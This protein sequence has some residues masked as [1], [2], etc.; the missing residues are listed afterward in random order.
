MALA[1]KSQS[2]GFSISPTFLI[3]SLL[4]VS[5]T[6]D[7]CSHNANLRALIRFPA[8][9]TNAP[10]SAEVRKGFPIR[11]VSS[12]ILCGIL[13]PQFG[14]FILLSG[15][16]LLHRHCTLTSSTKGFVINDGGVI[17]YR[18]RKMLAVMKALAASRASCGS[19]L[20]QP[21]SSRFRCLSSAFVRSVGLSAHWYNRQAEESTRVCCF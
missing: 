20:L 5:Y 8:A 15:Q 3:S 4:F 12:D 18:C 11:G 2:R 7:I 16:T 1:D 6:R 13:W 9:M 14:R 19:T 17:L 21:S 10:V